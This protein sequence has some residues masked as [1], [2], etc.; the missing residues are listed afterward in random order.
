M[1][2]MGTFPLILG[3]CSSPSD[4]KSSSTTDQLQ[5]IK[6]RMKSARRKLRQV[7]QSGEHPL[8]KLKTLQ[9]NF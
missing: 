3:V 1:E 6:A 5:Q 7:K 8:S 9:S 4:V 2:F